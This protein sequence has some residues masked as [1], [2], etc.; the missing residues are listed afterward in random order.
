MPTLVLVVDD[1]LLVRRA[2]ERTLRSAGGVVVEHVGAAHEAEARV[3]EVDFDLIVLDLQMPDATGV[4]VARRI[5]EVRP[6][7]RLIFISADT[8]SRIAIEARTIPSD[9]IFPKPWPTAEI[10]RIVRSIGEETR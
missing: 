10:L 6:N 7:Q 4:E 3:R 2:L 9:G 1:D 5:R 8:S